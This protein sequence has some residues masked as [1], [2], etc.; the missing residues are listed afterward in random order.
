MQTKEKNKSVARC[1]LV[2]VTALDWP[3]E[4]YVYYKI[5]FE[6]NDIK[7]NEFVQAQFNL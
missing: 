2:L 5:K 1:Y 7:N 3:W 4:I 6:T